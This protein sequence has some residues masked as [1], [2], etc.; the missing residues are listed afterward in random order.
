LSKRY[1]FESY[2]EY[3]A[4]GYTYDPDSDVVAVF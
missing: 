3:L 4:P 2:Y 1:E